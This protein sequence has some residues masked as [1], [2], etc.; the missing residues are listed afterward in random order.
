M[1]KELKDQIKGVVEKG[2]EAAKEGGEKLKPHAAEAAD[3]V[4]E[5]LKQGV[6][7]VKGF[8]K[9]KLSG[10][11]N[12][13]KGLGA[14]FGKMQTGNKVATLGGAT[15]ALDGV[16]R[17]ASGLKRDESGKRNLKI[18]FVGVIETA[19]G[20]VAAVTAFKAHG[21]GTGF[22]D[23]IRSASKAGPDGEKGGIGAVLNAASGFAD[24]IRASR[25]NSGEQQR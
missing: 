1:A 23:Y 16:R 17:V 15:A 13:V 3:R 24:K 10:L 14:D 21:Q 20:A 2:I 12:N 5:Q 9:E 11:L 4:Y 22:S 25:Q 19:L 8:D 7:Q 6:E 18:A